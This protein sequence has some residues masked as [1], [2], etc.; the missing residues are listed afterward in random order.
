[1]ETY[2]IESRYDDI[3]KSRKRRRKCWDCGERF[4]TYEVEKYRYLELI[5]KERMLDNAV[6]VYGGL[7]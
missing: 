1:M 2:V 6:K 3:K 7:K 4:T 5:K